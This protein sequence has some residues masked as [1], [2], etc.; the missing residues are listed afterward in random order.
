M[1]QDELFIL[2]ETLNE[3]S[4]FISNEIQSVIDE[5]VANEYNSVLSKIDGALQIVRKY[6]STP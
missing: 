5:D 4:Y 3:V 2:Y 6:K 1:K